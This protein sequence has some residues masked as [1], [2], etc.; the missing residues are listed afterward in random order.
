MQYHF[1]DARKAH[2]RHVDGGQHGL[3][4]SLGRVLSR[5]QPYQAVV[6]ST[7][8]V[9]VLCA[10]APIVASAYSITVNC[11]ADTPDIKSI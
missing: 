5:L 8:P 7:W 4:R 1:K 11:L 9:H 10:S 2:G 3:F 6:I